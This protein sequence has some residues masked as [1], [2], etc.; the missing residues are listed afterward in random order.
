M[1]A[2]QENC[3]FYIVDKKKMCLFYFC[4][5][6]HKLVLKVVLEKELSKGDI[7]RITCGQTFQVII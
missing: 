5:T 1:I 7:I 2:E 6:P 4:F 3:F